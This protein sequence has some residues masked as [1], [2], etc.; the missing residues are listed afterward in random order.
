MSEV[1]FTPRPVCPRTPITIL[2]Q[3][4]IMAIIAICCP[5]VEN[6]SC[7]RTQVSVHENVNWTSTKSIK[8]ATKIATQAAY[9]GV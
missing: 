7:K 2:A 3:R 4:V 9:C 8:T 5:A 1:I 6:T